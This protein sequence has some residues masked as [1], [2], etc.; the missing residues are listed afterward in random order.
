[1]GRD[2]GYSTVATIACAA[3]AA[4]TA[5]RSS[6]T[7]SPDLVTKPLGEGVFVDFELGDLHVLIGR[8]G[9]ESGVC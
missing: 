4:A 6:S 8:H 5:G 9:Y 2:E 1:M 7:R 3:A